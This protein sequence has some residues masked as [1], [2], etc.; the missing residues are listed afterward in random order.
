MVA[1]TMALDMP[2]DIFLEAAITAVDTT[3][4]VITDQIKYNK[5]V[6]TAL[7]LY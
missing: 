7:D 2:L 6:P 5:E 3:E 1:V 4:A